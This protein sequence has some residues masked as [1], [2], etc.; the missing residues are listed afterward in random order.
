M[1]S[2]GR[3]PPPRA[4]YDPTPP[5]PPPPPLSYTST[6]P[7]PSPSPTPSARARTGSKRNKSRTFISRNDQL[8]DFETES[9]QG[10]SSEEEL[11]D[12]EMLGNSIKGRNVTNIFQFAVKLISQMELSDLSR[13]LN[14][15]E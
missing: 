12:M 5:L 8:Y 13:T 11:P 14:Q 9:R 3:P 7:P 2:P 10:Q 4:W 15:G 6:L 1:Q